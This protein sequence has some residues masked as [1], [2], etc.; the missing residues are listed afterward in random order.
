M[1]VTELHGLW[2]LLKVERQQIG[3]EGQTGLVLA[4]WLGWWA[5]DPRVLSSN[6]TW[7]LN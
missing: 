3:G 5:W 2:N 4:Y 1:C 6:P 7:L